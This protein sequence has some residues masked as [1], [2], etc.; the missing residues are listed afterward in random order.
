M[1][2]VEI[3]TLSYLWGSSAWL[4]AWLRDEHQFSLH[5]TGWLA[6]VPF[7]ISLG[8]K[9]PG[10]VLPDKLRPAQA[11]LL[12][13]IG[14]ASTACAVT[15]LIMSTQPLWLAFWLLMANVC[16]GFAG[17]GDTNRGSASCKP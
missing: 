7:I 16:W 14:G 9:Y 2:L 10:G 12:F 1:L 17:R 5:A 11:P 13:V 6:A 15:G 3:A 8:A 4:P